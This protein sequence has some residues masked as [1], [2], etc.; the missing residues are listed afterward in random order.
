MNAEKK[1]GVSKK[2]W[3]L[4]II[5][6]V[7]LS[8]FIIFPPVFRAL[9]IGYEEEENQNLGGIQEEEQTKEIY[10]TK[11][12]ALEKEEYTFY[13][14][15]DTVEMI[16]ITNTKTNNN[17]TEIDTLTCNNQ[18]ETYQNKAGLYFMC[19]VTGNQI[20]T[21]ARITTKEFDSTTNLPFQV[22]YQKGLNALSLEFQQSGFNCQGK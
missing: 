8:T 2:E 5:G 16:V 10:C 15:G 13:A 7:I 6:I 9:E 12:S 22:N 20:I 14:K 3:T 1:L 18:I 21:S 17:I 11:Q 19:S 4:C